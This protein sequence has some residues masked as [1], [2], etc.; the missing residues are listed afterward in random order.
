MSATDTKPSFKDVIRKWL[1]ER[2]LTIESKQE[3]ENLAGVLTVNP[4]LENDVQL[5]DELAGDRW[6]SARSAFP[7]HL[8]REQAIKH[9]RTCFDQV[10]AYVHFISV[11]GGVLSSETKRSAFVLPNVETLRTVCKCVPELQPVGHGAEYRFPYMLL[12]VCGLTDA[13][14][15]AAAQKM[16]N[17]F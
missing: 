10:A 8:T 4:C 5:P 16:A 13:Q 1:D 3:K 12:S 7:S 9:L 14:L 2:L 17:K 6:K 15:I 11:A